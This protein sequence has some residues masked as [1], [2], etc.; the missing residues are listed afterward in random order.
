MVVTKRPV[1]DR[2]WEKVD[3][4]GDCW[5]W[6]GSIKPDGYGRFW[7]SVGTMKYHHRVVWELLVGPIAPGLQ[8]DHLCKNRS[9][10]NPDHLEPVTPKENMKRGGTGRHENSISAR[11]AGYE[12]HVNG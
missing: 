3:A 12:R 4:D 1:E 6:Q 11:K 10:V 7:V 5:Q 8:V 2:F 9:C